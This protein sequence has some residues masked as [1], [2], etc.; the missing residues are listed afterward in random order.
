[1]IRDGSGPQCAAGTFSG[2]GATA[3]VL[4]A[5]GRADTDVSPTT[6]CAACQPGLHTEPGARKCT[7][8]SS[9]TFGTD[10][11]IACKPCPKGSYSAPSATTCSTCAS[12]QADADNAAGTPCVD[13]AA[14]GLLGGST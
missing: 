14:G 1:M 12:G 10:P 11:S 7:A 13:C 8:C 6:P 9:G 5:A 4:C 3:C 2:S